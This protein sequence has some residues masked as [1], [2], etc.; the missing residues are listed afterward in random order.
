M[1]VNKVA[2]ICHFEKISSDYTDKQWAW[3]C[4]N[5]RGY[6]M[7]QRLTGTCPKVLKEK[8]DALNYVDAVRFKLRTGRTKNGAYAPVE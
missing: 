5:L 7:R 2:W 3:Y 4:D 1:I 6:I 8:M